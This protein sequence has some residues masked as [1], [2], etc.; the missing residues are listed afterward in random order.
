METTVNYE[1]EARL[2][3]L[4]TIVVEL[5]KRNSSICDDLEAII[6]EQHRAAVQSAQQPAATGFQTEVRRDMKPA[7]DREVSAALAKA[8]S[9]LA[10]KLGWSI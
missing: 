4:E 1:D 10:R 8:Y 9:S 3:A 6:G 5:A 2:T 7:V